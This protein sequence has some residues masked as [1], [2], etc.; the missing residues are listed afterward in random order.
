MLFHPCQPC[1]KQL[2][3]SDEHTLCILCLGAEHAQGAAR[4]SSFCTHRQKF[5]PRALKSRTPDSHQMSL[6]HR[7]MIIPNAPGLMTGL[8]PL[9]IRRPI[10]GS[11]HPHLGTNLNTLRC[12]RRLSH[13]TVVWQP[14]SMP[15]STYLPGFPRQYQT[16]PQPC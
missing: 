10:N 1:E 12:A 2:P 4:S 9:V 14:L 5:K 3:A 16:Q 15:L 8:T 6:L 11:A 13:W 7:S